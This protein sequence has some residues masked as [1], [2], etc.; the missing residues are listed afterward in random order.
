MPE[1]EVDIEALVKTRWLSIQTACRLKLEHNMRLTEWDM[2]EDHVGTLDSDTATHALEAMGL[3]IDDKHSSGLNC[4]K[5]K[6][7]EIPGTNQ[8]CS[9]KAYNKRLEG[10]Q[11]YLARNDEIGCKGARNLNPSTIELHKM[12]RRPDVHLKGLTRT[13]ATFFGPSI[14][15]IGLMIKELRRVS[16]S[17]DNS[18]V[19]CS[20]QEELANMERYVG[21]SVLAYW[22]DVYKDKQL[23]SRRLDEAERKQLSADEAKKVK[24]RRKQLNY[25]MEGALVRWSNKRTKKSNGVILKTKTG[26]TAKDS[27][28]WEGLC[29][30]AALATTCEKNPVLFVGVGG[31]EQFFKPGATR[32]PAMYFLQVELRRVGEHPLLTYL[33]YASDFK[34][35]NYLNQ[36]TSF[37]DCGINSTQLANIR[38]ACL[39]S[40]ELLDWD[41]IKLDIQLQD[42]CNVAASEHSSTSY[43]RVLGC[44][45]THVYS[46]VALKDLPEHFT[47]WTACRIRTYGQHHNVHFQVNGAWFRPPPSQEGVLKKLIAENP[48]LLCHVRRR[49]KAGGLE[50]QVQGSR[51]AAPK[52][53]KS[54]TALPVQHQPMVIISAL[55]DGRSVQVALNCVGSFYLPKT[56]TDC[57]KRL[58][59]SDKGFS[60]FVKEELPGFQVVHMESRCCYVKGGTNKEELLIILNKAGDEA[61]FNIP[62]AKRGAA[63]EH[64]QQASK[65]QRSS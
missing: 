39:A 38:P 61:A 13:E 48:N 12:M 47:P 33:P 45:K 17:L 15:P 35:G 65:R 52:G 37:F 25:L 16:A 7:Y 6:R 30:L 64:P 49:N 57:I 46:G 14:P 24:V 55:F 58:C 41:S 54:A 29:N 28:S 8:I 50:F 20:S 63:H 53:S 44:P 62:S 43:E 5:T 51:P 3:P 34:T 10:W 9:W 27:R 40:H 19:S 36:S 26:A 21:H 56:I 11:N 2:T 31:H 22:P 23:E 60:T 4:V 1:V 59:P 42:D 18:L 32:Q